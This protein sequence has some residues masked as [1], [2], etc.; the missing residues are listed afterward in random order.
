[1]RRNIEDEIFHPAWWRSRRVRPLR[2]NEDASDT[3]MSKWLRYLLQREFHAR[4][5]L[6]DRAL[7]LVCA[8]ATGLLLVGLTYLSDLASH[9]FDFIRHIEGIGPYIALAWT[10][11]ITVLIVWWTG[12]FA[13][14]AGGSGI[15]QVMRALDEDSKSERQAHLISL[16]TSLQKIVLVATGLLAGLS[17]GREGPAVQI[18]AGIMQHSRR[19][20]SRLSSISR[21]D[22]VVAGAAAGIAAAFNTPLG[23]VIFALEKLSSKHSKTRSALMIACIVMAGLIS[24][25]FFGNETY[26]GHLKVQ[27]LDWN[28]FIPGAL[29]ALS[30]GIAGGL[31]SRLVVLSLTSTQIWPNTWRSRHPLYFAGGAGFAVALIGLVTHNATSGTGYASTRA[32]LEGSE[33]FPV[34]YTWLKFCATWLSTWTG[35]P[36]GIFA[37]SLAIGAGIGHDIAML[38]RI[39]GDAAIPLVAL[40][41]V[42]FLAAT[43][44]GPITAF[45]IVMEM[46]SGYSMVLSLMASALL[47]S[48][49][50]RLIS[51]P[52]YTELAAAIAFP[53]ST[54]K[55]PTPKP[56]SPP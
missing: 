15:P 32:L 50:S 3:P 7:V 23:G 53:A 52:L 13:S 21:D 6:L 25:S 29:I 17:I 12:R 46:I 20:L 47:A 1:M 51:K 54:P 36:G 56:L 24:I 40:G 27:R 10:P 5:H 8:T 33:D 14:G 4:R 43:T 22:L 44:Q 28:L 31:F 49:V 38:F 37:P 30:A 48:R 18:G 42:G 55:S 9:F 35:A 34:M 26:F 11:A 16:K 19:W 45:I 39:G 2:S 41:M